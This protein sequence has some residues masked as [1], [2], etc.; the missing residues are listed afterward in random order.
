MT[1]MFGW[2][3]IVMRHTKR[4]LTLESRQ[5]TPLDLY[6]S[7]GKSVPVLDLQGEHNAVTV[8]ERLSQR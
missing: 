2:M 4:R 3:A 6:F 7:A 5:V 8:K 1:R